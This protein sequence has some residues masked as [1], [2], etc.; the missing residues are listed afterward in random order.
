MNKFIEGQKVIYKL[1]TRGELI[2]N[3]IYTVEKVYCKGKLCKLE[4][5]G[6]HDWWCGAFEDYINE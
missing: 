1:H 4:G 5:Y 6:T 2:Y 3:C